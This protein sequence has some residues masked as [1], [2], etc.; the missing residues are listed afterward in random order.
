MA[1]K[2][3]NRFGSFLCSVYQLTSSAD[4]DGATHRHLDHLVCPYLGCKEDNHVLVPISSHLFARHWLDG[5]LEGQDVNKECSTHSGGHTHDLAKH[6]VYTSKKLFI[7]RRLDIPQLDIR[8]AIEDMTVLVAFILGSQNSGIW[9]LIL[10]VPPISA[11][12]AIVPWC[13][14]VDLVDLSWSHLGHTAV[15]S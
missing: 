1:E 3:P 11:R 7:H 5:F 13:F 8:R 10:G 12:V 14:D 4:H 6:R 15:L 2:L 9:D